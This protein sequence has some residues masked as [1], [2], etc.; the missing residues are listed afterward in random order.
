MQNP[1]VSV[2]K[3][4]IPDKWKNVLI[5]AREYIKDEAPKGLHYVYLFGSLSRSELSY[6]SDI[7]LCLVFDDDIDLRDRNLVIF[8]GMLRSISSAVPIDVICCSQST[9]DTSR[10]PLF[11]NI[12]KDGRELVI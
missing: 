7:D 11:V 4:T 12:R 10:E 6:N 5:R 9:F 3:T 2:E 1:V 8:K